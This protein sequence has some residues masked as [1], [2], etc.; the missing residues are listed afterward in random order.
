M[1][2]DSLQN[3]ITTYGIEKMKYTIELQA[4]TL[5]AIFK[6]ILVED[7]RSLCRDIKALKKE[8]K[9]SGLKEYQIEDLS[10]NIRYRD[11]LKIAI[12]YY[13][14]HDEAREILGKKHDKV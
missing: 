14:A 10:D 13:F 7:Y 2:V 6:Q 8:R 12:T 1:V 4:D 11:A 5:D 3:T 9:T